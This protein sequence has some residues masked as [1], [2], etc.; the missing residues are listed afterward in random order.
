M[1]TENTIKSCHLTTVHGRYDIRIF[2]KQCKS[3]AKQDYF[4]VALVVAD[5]KG[6]EVKDNISIYDIGKPIGRVNR[7]LKSTKKLY[8]K[9]LQLNSEVYHLHDP[10]LIPMGLKLK[11]K[12]KKVIFD[13]HE[14]FPKQL[15]S[16]PYLNGILKR[17]LPVV[18]KSYEKYAFKKFDYLVGATPYITHKLKQINSNSININN[19]PIIGELDENTAWEAKKNE[20]SYIGGISTIRGIHQ[21]IDAMSYVSTEV[22]LNL[23]GPFS[24]TGLLEKVKQRPG[25]K[26]VTYHGVLDRTQVSGILSHS[27]AGLVTFLNA[28]NHTDAQPNK[29]FEYMSVGI[30]VIT[31]DF[32]LWKKIVEGN[33]CGVT[34]NPEN[35]EEIANAIDKILSDDKLAHQM[36]KNGKAAVAG[37]Y[38]WK[39]EEVKL[40]EMYNQ[41]C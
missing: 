25:W 40:I 2:V 32:P 20:I 16:K 19:F 35:P 22:K 24:E 6:N 11:K 26:K 27:K 4:N 12:G 41:I 14:D 9:A 37:K 23:A 31:S 34:V 7:I 29:M 8:K 1:D 17:I 28:P 21:I 10:E 3:L 5:G 30:P 15:R 33:H 18:L 36:G 13:A 39:K 38:N